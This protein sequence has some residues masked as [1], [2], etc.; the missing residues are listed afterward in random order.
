M[1]FELFVQRFKDGDSAPM[2]SGAFDVFRPHVDRTEPQFHFW[3][4]RTADGEA[5]I[6]ANIE[7][8]T[9]GSLMIASFSG[10]AVLGLLIEFARQADAVILAP[11]CPSLLMAETQREHLPDELQAD[12]L[13]VQ[14][15][16]GIQQVL[17]DY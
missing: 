9:F 10:G 2:P 12:T 14:G 8:G 1:S 15:A 16:D 5:E 3:H 11:G 7:S 4:V 6:F 13:V 17:S